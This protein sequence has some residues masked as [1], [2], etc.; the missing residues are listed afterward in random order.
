[1]KKIFYFNSPVYDYLDALLIQGFRVA[2]IPLKTRYPSNYSDSSGEFDGESSKYPIVLVGSNRRIP[3]EEIPKSAIGCLCLIDGSD[4]QEIT[5]NGLTPNLVFKRELSRLT[6]PKASSVFPLPLGCESRYFLSDRI[7]WQDRGIPVFFSMNLHNH[8]N[9]R[10]AYNLLRQ[11]GGTDAYLGSTGERAYNPAKPQAMPIPTPK[12]ES[13]MSNSKIVV[14]LP[15][16][17][18]DTARFWEAT[19]A[20]CCV[21]ST[22]LD[23]EIEPAPIG[24]KTH[25]FVRSELDLPSVITS[26]LKDPVKA[27]TIAIQG[28]EWAS[29]HHTSLHRAMYVLR[30]IRD[31][32]FAE[33]V[34]SVVEHIKDFVF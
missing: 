8:P 15:G 27:K 5:L 13:L 18:F 30:I 20:G 26:L 4:S 6:K 12:Y 28:K 25:I 21:I 29:G 31:K 2:R 34:N 14:S 22:F 10:L 23:L 1:V 24:D 3:F 33:E 32:G 7:P 9:R 19:S 17:G 16:A 11:F